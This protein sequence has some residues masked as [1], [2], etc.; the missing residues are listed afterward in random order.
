M[1]DLLIEGLQNYSM[2]KDDYEN[3]ILRTVDFEKNNFNE[4]KNVLN[5]YQYVFKYILHKDNNGLISYL[6]NNNI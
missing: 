3:I 6:N 5:K 1:S 2:T 4:I